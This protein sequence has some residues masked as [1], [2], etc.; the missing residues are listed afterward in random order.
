METGAGY[1]LSDI[2]ALM[3]DRGD[4]FLEGNGIIILI[5]FFLIFGG[6]GGWGYGNAAAQGA[7][8][9]AELYDGLNDNTVIRKLDGITNGLSDGFYAQNT[10][11]L[12]GFNTIGSQIA[13]NR[14]AAQQCC[15][16]TNRNIDAVRY[17]AA[18]NTCDIVRAIEKDGDATRALINAN[19]MQA[20]R[21]KLVEKDQMLQ[22]ANF[23]LSQ[24]AQS[25][26]LIS[27]LRPCAK[28][29]Y[30]TCSPYEVNDYG[31]SRFNRGCG[32][33]F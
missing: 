23:Q 29:A 13:E 8:T 30:L 12:Q 21:D 2:A 33:G 20:L 9:R 1:S 22:T 31:Y 19:T 28:P 16:E 24:Q 5:L 7:L 17:E 11:M 3:R 26:N 32:C 10:T 14:F 4:G 18:K 25:A 6:N 27:E 15:C